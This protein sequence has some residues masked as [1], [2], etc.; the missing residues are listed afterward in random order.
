MFAVLRFAP[1]SIHRSPGQILE[2]AL[3]S[4]KAAV[5]QLQMLTEEDLSDYGIGFKQAFITRGNALLELQPKRQPRF[6]EQRILVALAPEIQVET[7]RW[8]RNWG[9]EPIPVGDCPAAYRAALQSNRLAL[10]LLDSRLEGYQGN[11][12]IQAIRQAGAAPV[13]VL[14]DCEPSD[15][16]GWLPQPHDPQQL[17]N[18]AGRFLTNASRQTPKLNGELGRNHPLK[19]LIAEDLALNQKLIGLLLSRLGYLADT[20]NNGYEVMLKVEQED[21]DLILMDLNM[22][23]MNGLEAARRVRQLKPMDRGG[24]RLV[25]M[26]ANLPGG[27]PQGAGFEEFLAKPVQLKELQSV[28]KSCP[29]RGEGPTAHEESTPVLDSTILENLKRLG[30]RE[31]L[32]SLIDDAAQELPQLLGLLIDCWQRGDCAQVVQLAHGIKGSASTLGAAKVARFAGEIEQAAKSGVLT[33][34]PLANL[35]IALDE[36]LVQLQKV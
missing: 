23:G 30:D 21:Y 34:D 27:S 31:F 3:A 6:S 20:A 14:S 15:A 22:P 26:S 1:E 35:E 33:G 5:S 18:L 13:L 2:K 36:A 29:S 16:D 9:L 10:V 32:E 11:A 4:V 7:C 24:P 8:L 28:L 19:I 17:L 25:A 12:S